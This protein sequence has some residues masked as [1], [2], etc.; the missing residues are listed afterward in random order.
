MRAD[1]KA[2]GIFDSGIGGLTVFQALK[3]RLPRERL[4]YFGDTAHL[5]YGSKSPEAVRG[6]AR[7]IACFLVGLKI[8]ALV[9]ACNTASAVALAELKRTLDIPVLGVIR[10]G[11][12][13]AVKASRGGRIGIIG[14]EAMV[15]SKAY[16][17]AIHEYRPQA[18][19]FA[20]AC[21]LLVPFVEEAWWSGALVTAAVRRY[22][23]GLKRSR[24]DTLILG[25]THYPLLKG[26]L[27]RV[28]G[29][30]V[31]LIDSAQ[32]VARE[33]ADILEDFKLSSRDKGRPRH[34]FMVSDNRERFQRVAR[35]LLGTDVGPV[36]LKILE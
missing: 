26:V 31:R 29:P 34:R 24:I 7:A 27:R 12:R 18:R 36:A 33:T 20:A 14:T 8:K 19:V 21:P 17:R 28:M 23:M 6:H 5:P 1:Q 13:A 10:P 2:I 35:R 22:L 9:V 11:A 4:I 16:Q 3:K 30:R 15:S 25:C 32:E